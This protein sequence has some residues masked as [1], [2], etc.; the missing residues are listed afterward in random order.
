[1]YTDKHANIHIY[2]VYWKSTNRQAL[3]NVDNRQ[4]IFIDIRTLTH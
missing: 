3:N 2:T 1:M 4:N